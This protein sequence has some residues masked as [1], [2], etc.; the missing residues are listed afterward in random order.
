ML[1]LDVFIEMKIPGF[2][3]NQKD[4]V[5]LAVSE[6]GK[7]LERFPNH[8]AEDEVIRVALSSDGSAIQY[9][10]KGLRDDPEYIRHAVSQ[11]SWRNG[12]AARCMKKY[13][14]NEVYVKMALEVDGSNIRYAS[15]RLRND[16]D[17]AKFA[18]EH[19]ERSHGPGAFRYL[20]A[21]LRDN[22]ELAML[23]IKMGLA[24]VSSF[25]RRLKDSDE[26]AEALIAEDDEWLM[27][28]MSARVQRK[29]RED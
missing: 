27:Y 16:Y 22:T 10:A 28:Q 20:S 29:Y 26:I 18:I 17:V 11:D 19:Q 7:S 24:D 14:D 21:A 8:K 9:V 3:L 1:R 15:L 25:S 6:Y 13:R 2:A 4:A 5:L 23:E 12:L